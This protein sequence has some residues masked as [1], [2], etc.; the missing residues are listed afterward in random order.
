M[1]HW[2]R[3][4]SALGAAGGLAQMLPMLRFQCNQLVVERLDPLVTPGLVPSPHLHQIVGGDS[5][6]ASLDAATH[7]LPG[8]SACTSCT[9]AEDLSNYWTAP[10]SQRRRRLPGQP[11]RQ[12]PAADVRSHVGRTFLAAVFFLFFSCELTHGLTRCPPN[13]RPFNDPELWP[14]DGSQPFYWSTNDRYD[15]CTHPPLHSKL[16]YWGDPTGPDTPSTAIMSL[17]GKTTRSSGPWMRAVTAPSAAYC[18]LRRSRNRLHAPSALS[19]M[20]MS[21]DVSGAYFLL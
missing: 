10:D 13:T 16:Q 8:L 17:V 21:T 1:M 3:R 11:P 18:S 2:N 5:F 4:L 12:D 7:D 15:F 9:F 19:S 20:K 6:N 14:E